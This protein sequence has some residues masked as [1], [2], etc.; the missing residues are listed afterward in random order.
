[1]S[2]FIVASNFFTM[3]N[4]TNTSELNCSC[5]SWLAHWAAFSGISSAPRCHVDGCDALAEVGAHVF[6]PNISDAD[7]QGVSFI[8][9]MCKSHNA[10]SSNMKSKLKMVFVYA[11]KLRTC[12]MSKL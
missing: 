3:R 1:M 7:L 10:S 4:Q 9:P 8:A 12:N 5:E 11:D 2:K 6:L